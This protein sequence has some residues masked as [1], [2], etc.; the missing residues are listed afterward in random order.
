VHGLAQPVKVVAAPEFP[1]AGGD[2]L[3]QARVGRAAAGRQAEPVEGAVL[4]LDRRAN[5][6]RKLAG[7]KGQDFLNG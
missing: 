1:V 4:A 3:Q 7:R 5:L 2:V 6:V